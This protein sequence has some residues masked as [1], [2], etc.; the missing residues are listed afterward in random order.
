MPCGWNIGSKPKPPVP[1]GSAVIF[2]M[3]S[4]V[5]MYV[6]PVG[7]FRAIADLNT[8]VLSVACWSSCSMPLHPIVWYT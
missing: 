3:V 5:K 7:V 4:P 2:P 1:R 8:A 6:S